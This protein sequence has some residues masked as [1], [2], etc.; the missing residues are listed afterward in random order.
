MSGTNSN[1]MGFFFLFLRDSRFPPRIYWRA[2]SYSWRGVLQRK[3]R[4]RRW[5]KKGLKSPPNVEKRWNQKGKMWGRK[6]KEKGEIE[7]SLKEVMKSSTWLFRNKQRQ[8][9][10]IRASKQNKNIWGEG[11]AKFSFFNLTKSPVPCVYIYILYLYNRVMDNRFYSQIND[12]WIFRHTHT[13]YSVA[14]ILLYSFGMCA[15]YTKK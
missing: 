8:Y 4:E 9:C 11:R 6:K 2:T 1:E 12:F 15:Y 7:W 5:E 13:N 3:D 14:T 10:S